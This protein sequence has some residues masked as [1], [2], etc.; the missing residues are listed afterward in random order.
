MDTIRVNIEKTSEILLEFETLDEERYA[1][2]ILEEIHF[3]KK[4][5]T[6]L[7]EA[8]NSLLFKENSND[9]KTFTSLEGFEKFNEE[10]SADIS[11]IINSADIDINKIQ[12]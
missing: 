2:S 3:Q 5:K 1:V 4:L 9:Y 7:N 10:L 8:F 6:M 12:D 11:Q